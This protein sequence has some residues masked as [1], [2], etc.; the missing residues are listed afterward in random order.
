MTSV[1]DILKFYFSW[2]ILFCQFIFP[3]VFL[4]LHPRHMLVPG[5]GVELEL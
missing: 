2:F 1:K 3:H 5:L 4:G